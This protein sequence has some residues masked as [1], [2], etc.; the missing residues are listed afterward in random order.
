VVQERVAVVEEEALSQFLDLVLQGYL[1]I[2]LLELQAL[3]EAVA[4]SLAGLWDLLGPEF[5]Q[6]L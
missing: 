4:Y 1:K 6:F 3:E 2:L 5:R